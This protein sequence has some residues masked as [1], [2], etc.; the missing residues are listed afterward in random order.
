MGCHNDNPFFLLFN[1]FILPC[2]DANLFGMFQAR[3]P[4]ALRGGVLEVVVMVVEVRAMH[5][6]VELT[7]RHRGSSEAS[8][9]ARLI[10]GERVLRYEHTDVRED[11]RIVF[12]MA[13]AVGRDVQ[14]Q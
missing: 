14:Y 4:F 10:Q 12:R 13:V 9:Y 1:Q 2:T 6:V 11:R 5:V 7:A 8:I 3:L